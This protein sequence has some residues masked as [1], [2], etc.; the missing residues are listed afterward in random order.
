MENKTLL[1]GLVEEAALSVTAINESDISEV[2]N[3]I[4]TLEK[5]RESL[6]LTTGV[7]DEMVDKSCS[8]VDGSLENLK[9]I[10]KEDSKDSNELIE[11]VS[12]SLAQLV[13]LTE[14]FNNPE[15][16]V[17][18][19]E[20]ETSA[21]NTQEEFIISEDD[22]PL[23]LDFIT[24]AAEH[25]ENSEA[26][27]LELEAEPDNK[28]KI[29][30]IFRGFHTIKGMAGF[31]NL[32]DIGSLAHSAENLLDLARKDELSLMGSNT[33]VIFSSMDMMKRMLSDLKEAMENA[34][35]VKSQP[36]LSVL[37]DT[38]EACASDNEI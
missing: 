8:L 4:Q 25:L 24:E 29:N 14:T 18:Q 16:T 10:S 3:L 28:D 7:S 35:P 20:N 32:T 15:S 34:S 38:L 13:D 9:K 27:L 21:Q 23:V 33:D 5:I 19:I 6:G 2:G 31:L 1:T 37:L 22:A 36:D 12:E 26:A 30:T 17:I 11:F